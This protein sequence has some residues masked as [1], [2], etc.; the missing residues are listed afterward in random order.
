MSAGTVPQ[1]TSRETTLYSTI[2]TKCAMPLLFTDTSSFLIFE[3]FF[4]VM[5]Y[6]KLKSSINLIKISTPAF[7]KDLFLKVEIVL[8]KRQHSAKSK[9]NLYQSVSCLFKSLRI[10]AY[11][12]FL[13][14]LKKIY[15]KK[16]IMKT[17]PKL[18]DR[19]TRMNKCS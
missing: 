13:F 4:H 16:E 1:A 12:Q 6:S 3:Y 17:N 11:N 5:K 10:Q 18:I 2:V 7:N 8:N 15:K 14:Y 19:S 9:K